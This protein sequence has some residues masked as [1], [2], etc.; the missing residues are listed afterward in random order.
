[1]Q[2]DLTVEHLGGLEVTQGDVDAIVAA[3][4]QIH[5]RLLPEAS[6]FMAEAATYHPEAPGNIVGM[7]IGE[8][9][10]SGR[11]TGKPA[12]KILVRKKVAPGLLG[13][14]TLVPKEINGIP[15]DVDETGEIVAYQFQSRQRPAPGGVSI[16]RCD[17]N[18]AGTLGCWVLDGVALQILSNNHVMA[19]SNDGKP[20]DPI[21]QQ[22]RLD[23]GA[24]PGDV[25]ANLTRFIPIVYGGGSNLVDTAIAAATDKSV[26]EPRI[27]RAEGQLERL[28]APHVKATIGMAVQKSGRTTGWTH[29]RV[30]LIGVTVNVT[31][32]GHGV[33]RFDNQFRVSG[34]SGA[35]STEGDSGSLVTTD[36]A[37][38]RMGATPN[39]PVGLLFSGGG[40]FTF[41][42]DIARVLNAL[43]IA[44]YY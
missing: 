9:T 32:P 38:G 30:D 36:S 2:P 39:Q 15:T 10:T 22:G 11:G 4:E 44:I 28:S 20:G 13:E 12:L 17:E 43:K 27:L 6:V 16:G 8:K 18:A 25:I 37:A 42:N 26:V 19:A 5:A 34:V 40:G 41:C 31:Y 33:G 3:F 29:G 23:G 14:S 1:M 24:C 21:C 7:G 35:F